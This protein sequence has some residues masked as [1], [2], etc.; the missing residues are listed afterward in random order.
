MSHQIVIKYWCNKTSIQQ[1]KLRIY[2][3][4]IA[5]QKLFNAKI[6]IASMGGYGI[7]K[8][9]VH[10]LTPFPWISIVAGQ[11]GHQYHWLSSPWI[12]KLGSESE[13]HYLEM[14]PVKFKFSK[15]KKSI[16]T[17]NLWIS[18]IWRSHSWYANCMNENCYFGHQ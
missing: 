15:E 13:W 9:D 17:M 14:N 12:M 5:A 2:A 16:S 18:T 8:G 3:K 11:L 4:Q 6:K 1:V 10:P 7:Q